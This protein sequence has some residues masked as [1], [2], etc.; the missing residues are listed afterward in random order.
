MMSLLFSGCGSKTEVKYVL[1]TGYAM[2]DTSSGQGG[3]QQPVN[4]VIK[5][6]GD[7]GSNQGTSQPQQTKPKD[8]NTSQFSTVVSPQYRMYNE[9]YLLDDASVD[10]VKAKLCSINDVILGYVGCWYD[11]EKNQVKVTLKN[12]GRGD[13]E[14]MWFYVLFADRTRYYKSEGFGSGYINDYTLPVDDWTRQFGQIQRILMTPVVK[15]DAM[16]ACNN[17]QMLLLPPV[18]C[19]EMVS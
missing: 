18:N 5:D 17:R 1:P 11:A 9:S 10:S 16:Y 8:Y 2:L 19:R 12:S 7:S 13:V 6:S 3:V 14:E 15:E 4:V